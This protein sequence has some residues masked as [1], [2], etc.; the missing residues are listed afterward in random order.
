MT[1][2]STDLTYDDCLDHGDDCNGAVEFRMPLSATGR[3]FPRCDHHWSRRLDWQED[4][5]RKYGVSDSDVPPAW[6]DPTYAG[7]RWSEDD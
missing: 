7:E 2:V 5:V 1:L 4:H 6:F 3:A